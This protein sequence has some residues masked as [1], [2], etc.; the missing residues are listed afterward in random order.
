MLKKLKLKLKLRARMLVYIISVVLVAFAVTITFVAVKASNLAETEAL[1]KAKEMAYRHGNQVQAS[2]EVALDAA[3]TLAHSLEGMKKRGVP[4]RDMIDGILKNVL[5]QNPSFIGA[6]TCWEP[7]ALDGRDQDFINAVG[8]DSTGRYLPYWNRV[9]GEVDIE[10]LQNYTEEGKGDY[11]LIPKKTGKETILEPY[12]IKVQG[13]DVLM[14]TLAVPIKYA[15]EVV[16]VAGVDMSLKVF[17]ELIDGIKPYGTGYAFFASNNGTLVGHPKHDIIGEFIGNYG[18]AKESVKA[19]KHG[20]EAVE[21]KLA[22]LTGKYSYLVY[23]PIKFGLTDNPWSFGVNIPV[24]AIL[25]GAHNIMYTTI[26]IGVLSVLILIA[27]VFF[28]SKGITGPIVA[29][30]EVIRKVATERD[31]TIEVPVKGSDE[32]GEMG[33]E[34]NNMLHQLSDS[35]GVVGKAAEDV[36]THAEDVAKRAAANK[37]R[38]EETV[39]KVEKTAEILSKMGETAGEV[40]T[41]SDAQKEAAEESTKTTEK[42]TTA[43]ELVVE[44]VKA[45]DKEA[46]I[47]TERVEEMGETGSQVVAIAGKQGESVKK[48]TEAM[49]EM[50]KSVEQMNKASIQATQYGENSLKAVVEGSESVAATVDGMRAISESSEQIAEI[51]TVITEIAEQTNLLSLNAAIEA[52]RAGEHGKGFAVVADEVGKLAQR[53]SEAAK[54]ITQ[55][56]K[57]SANRVSEGT[58]LSTQS[59]KALEKIAEGGETNLKAIEDISNAAKLMSE[60]AEKVNAM[61]ED[62]NVLALEIGGMAGQQG[63]RRVATQTALEV[64]VEKSREIAGMVEQANKDAVDIAGEMKGIVERTGRMQKMTTVQAERSQQ[65]KVIAEEQATGARQTVQGAGRVVQ[66]TDELQNLSQDLTDQVALYKI[67]DSLQAEPEIKAEGIKA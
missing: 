39:P 37:D 57:D 3:R 58:K 8:H 41:E 18:V 17:I 63:E 38:A 52:A 59:K 23:A 7:N 64:L 10:A 9:G 45:Q 62:L 32:I 51:T 11:Y 61:M 16:A 34:F 67:D 28:I 31:L 4:P 20:K 49:G 33:K 1:D 24:E 6:W 40:A 27:V 47:A 13:K 50:A 25:E 66:I 44:S 35:F 15:G 56:I 65:V 12:K 2:V 54:E 5:E 48:V 60:S 43:M 30:S 21:Y 55:L 22:T 19:I 14:T 29:A 26:I 42:L 46:K 36:V 53:S